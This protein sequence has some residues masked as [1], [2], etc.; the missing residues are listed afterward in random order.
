MLDGAGSVMQEG[1]P[2]FYR[3]DSSMRGRVTAAST[4][5]IPFAPKD[6]RRKFRSELAGALT[7]LDAAED[8]LVHAVYRG[9]RPVNSDVENILFYNV[10][11]GVFAKASQHGLRFSIGDAVSSGVV[12]EYT[13]ERLA[14]NFPVLDAGTTIA[15]VR[16]EFEGSFDTCTK[17][18]SQVCGG[19]RSVVEFPNGLRQICVRV[20]VETSR[21]RPAASICKPL[22]DGIL[23]AFHQHDGSNAD[24]I[25]GRLLSGGVPQTLVE[26]L[27]SDRY[28]VLGARRLLWPWKNGLQWNPADDMCVAGEVI[29]VPTEGRSS[30]I[31]ADLITLPR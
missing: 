5:S 29:V 14:D 11:V 17:V 31:S 25:G 21:P 22:I 28:A 7:S 20:R 26:S 23:C 2:L 3:V 12:Y 1:S 6:W 13:L 9:A 18:W 15:S 10:G 19:Q 27:A 8:E 4:A 30:V 24:R 16:A